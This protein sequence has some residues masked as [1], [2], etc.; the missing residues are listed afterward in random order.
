MKK[1]LLIIGAE[2]PGVS[3]KKIIEEAEKI[4]DK[5]KFVPVND[6]VLRV[7]KKF[8][9]TYKGEDLTKYD[10][11]LPRIDSKRASHGYHVI[12]F[13]DILGMKK[14]YSAESIIIAHNKFLSLDVLR[15]AGVPI[16]ETYLVS[17]IESAEQ[18]LKKMKYPIVVKIASGYGG[19]GVMF[20]EDRSAAL[21]AVETMIE[22]KHQVL[23][24]EFLKNPGEDN[25]AYVVGGR[26]VAGYK[27]KCARDELRSNMLV[28]GTAEYT[29]LSEEM[30]DIAIKAA[31]AVGSDILAVDIIPSDKGPRVVEVNLNSGL[32]GIQSY[33]NVAKIIV[34]WI[35][36]QVEK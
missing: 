6:I 1:S 25:R 3:T 29:N 7:N 22:R 10:Y 30:K 24:E 21:S 28:G 31:A 17:S 18:V 14:P 15:Q 13:M 12:K 34:E 23:I 26:V 2:K 16:P 20:F 9:I 35:A 33:V 8:E 32:K 36:D 19:M 4:F 27:R 5:V 11:C